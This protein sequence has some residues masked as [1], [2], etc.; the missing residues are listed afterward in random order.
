MSLTKILKVVKLY[1]KLKMEGAMKQKKLILLLLIVFALVANLSLTRADNLNTWIKPT[2]LYGGEINDVKFS[3]NFANDKTVF[4]G[5]PEGVYVSYDGGSNWNALIFTGGEGVTSIALSSNFAT[6][7]T[8]IAGSKNGVYI[9]NNAGSS[10]SS[11]QKG[12]PSAYIID[13]ESNAN[14]DYFALSFDG[15]FTEKKPTEDHWSVIQTFQTIVPNTF[16]VV[17][18][19]VYVGCEMGT[20]YKVN[21]LDDTK[22]SIASN[23]TEGAI[24]SISVKENEVVISTYD[25]GVF[26]SSNGKNFSH[27]LQGNK[28]SSVIISTEGN[29]YA[30]ETYGGVKVKKGSF[31]QDLP[32]N[33]SSTNISF[34]LAPDFNT[35]NT[36]I[37]AS[38]E[39]GIIKSNDLKMLSA[40]NNGITN[41]NVSSIGFSKQYKDNTTIYLGTLL[42]GLY[43]SKNG[44]K[45]FVN[46]NNMQLHQITSI[47]ELSTGSLAAGTFGE[48]IWVS[49]DNGTSFVQAEILK[50]DSISFVEEASSGVVVV[51][52]KNDGLYLTN[53]QFKNA[54]KAKDLWSI[55]TNI[56][57]LRTYGENIFTG[58]S[59]GSLYLSSDNGKTFKE[60]A[61]NA[62][63]GLAITGLA[64]SPNY[65]TDGAI[66]V[67]TA[68]GEFLSRDKGIHFKPIYDLGT[69]W[70]DGCAF[71]PN[72][73][74][75]STAVVGAWGYIYVTSNNFMSFNNIYSNISNRYIT[76][77]ALTPDF[78]YGKSGSIIVLTS[79]GGIF[80]LAQSLPIVVKMTIG[81]TGMDVNG[82][83]IPTDTAPVIK[84]SRTLVPIRFI[85]DAFGANVEWNDKEKKV[86][87]MLDHHEI[88][89]YIGKA[90]AYV[91]GKEMQIDPT[92]SK[93]VPEIINNRTY[94]PVRFI[95][96]GFN[97][98]IEWNDTL[99]EVTITLGGAQ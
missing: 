19:S 73:V 72:F 65:S 55:D 88:V 3:P 66:L 38:Y 34:A 67:G 50:T 82:K 8:L 29:I 39:Y 28:L 84:N 44:G 60:V 26:I 58:T 91:D 81:K 23:L 78:S 13:V 97:A 17:D 9:S 90:T 63:W 51:G 70:A 49:N 14:G 52:T 4:A 40:S 47:T 53:L 68:G 54:T 16:A 56:S 46:T 7:H 80:N 87:V 41:V 95:S 6:D 42:N 48:G 20:I 99:K 61:N 10:W 62:F 96:E 31:W 18:N 76:Q 11:F 2:G 12:A 69:T 85:S 27:E 36:M 33:I 22:E 45:S 1:T 59:G 75:D 24:S 77:V 79:S 30:L 92:N 94:V 83:F 43:I 25:D 57:A 37:I 74:T 35:S 21:L 71:S 98:K 86:S 93:V 32:I 89:L 5:G 15:F 64:I